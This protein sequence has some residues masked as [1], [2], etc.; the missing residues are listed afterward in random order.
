M[1]EPR[2]TPTPR[3]GKR[4][5]QDFQ[6]RQKGHDSTYL[7]PGI[8]CVRCLGLR[9]GGLGVLVQAWCLG[10]Q[11]ARTC[12][13]AHVVVLPICRICSRRCIPFGKAENS[14]KLQ[15]IL[16]FEICVSCSGYWINS[17]HARYL[18]LGM[19][20]QVIRFTR[21]RTLSWPV[22]GC[23]G[24][25]TQQKMIMTSVYFA[26]GTDALVIALAKR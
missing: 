19:A 16:F 6:I 14:E 2:T 24:T 21:I 8:V 23:S 4:L 3:E 18:G 17:E 22:H 26:L 20:A 7:G 15:Y 12:D 13:V 10:V 11:G 5:V 25:R 1:R 9:V